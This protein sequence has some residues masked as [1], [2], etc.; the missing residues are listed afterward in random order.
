MF[1]RFEQFFNGNECF[2]QCGGRSLSRTRIPK[3]GRGLEQS[4]GLP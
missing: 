4:L 3:L 2:R 1:N